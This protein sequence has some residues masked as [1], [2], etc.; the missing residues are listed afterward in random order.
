MKNLKNL[1]KVLT[2]A[3]QKTINGGK[4]NN[5]LKSVNCECTDGSSYFVGS[6]RTFTGVMELANSCKLD[7][8]TPSI[9]EHGF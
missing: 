4:L 2:N 1:G 9:F 3:E 7:G 5:N 6:S 8:G